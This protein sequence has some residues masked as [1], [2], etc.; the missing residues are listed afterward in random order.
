MELNVPQT[1]I[2]RMEE[3]EAL[4]QAFERTI[5]GHKELVLT[6]GE[7]GVGKTVFA[8]QLIRPVSERAGLFFYGKFDQASQLNIYKSLVEILEDFCRL[9]LSEPAPSF[10]KWRDS[11]RIAV[12]PHGQLLTDLCPQFEKIIGPQPPVRPVDEALARP[13]FHQVVIRFLQ[14]ICQADHPVVLFLD[15]LQ[16]ITPDSSLLWQ[17]ILSTASLKNLL[18]VG[19]YRDSEVDS[20]HPLHKWIQEMEKSN[21]RVTEIRVNNLEWPLIQTL[22]AAALSSNPAEI[23]EL[24]TLIYMRN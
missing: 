23:S 20:G 8:N 11:I 12:A 22:I 14:A 17:S 6:S 21:E 3:T 5:D 4:V 7:A 13:R 2:G 9:V 1:I 19:A 10:E 15:D 24:T 16:W 18:V